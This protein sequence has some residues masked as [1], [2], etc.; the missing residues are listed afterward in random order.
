LWQP[1]GLETGLSRAHIIGMKL[2]LWIVGYLA[3][4]A[5]AAAGLW[6]DCFSYSLMIVLG[7]IVWIAPDPAVILSIRRFRKGQS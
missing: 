6:L 2:K 5:I 4:A 1:G 3:V 7:L